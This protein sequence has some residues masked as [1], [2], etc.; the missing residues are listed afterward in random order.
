MHLL[1]QQLIYSVNFFI[2][3]S[4]N[5]QNRTKMIWRRNSVWKFSWKIKIKSPNTTNVITKERYRSNWDWTNTQICCTMSSLLI[6]MD[7]TV[8][9]NWSEEILHFFYDKFLFTS[10]LNNCFNN[11]IFFIQ[12]IECSKESASQSKSQFSLLN[13]PMLRFQHQST[14]EKKVPLLK[15]KIRVTVVPAGH[16]R[17]LELWKDNISAN[18]AYLCHCRN[19]TW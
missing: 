19:R 3:Y 13:Q 6:W 18:R 17:Q 1:Y 7:S 11:N 8:P 15:L 2:V 10:N 9:P 4:W 12:S 16:S 14:G 5:I